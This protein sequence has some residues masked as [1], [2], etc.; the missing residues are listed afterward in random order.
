MWI[1]I[2]WKDARNVWIV[3]DNISNIS[4]HKVW[5]AVK[6]KL[7]THHKTHFSQK[8]ATLLRMDTAICRVGDMHSE[9]TQLFLY[10]SWGEHSVK[11]VC[12]ALEMEA[13]KEE[14]SDVVHF[15]VAEVVGTC[16]IHHLM[17]AVSGKHCMSL[18]KRARVAEEI[19]QRMHI[20]ASWFASRAGLLSLY[21]WYDCVNWWSD[22]GKTTNQ[23]KFMFRSDEEVRKWV[24]LWIHQWLTS[25]Y[26][27]GIDHLVSQSNK[28][29]NT[30]GNYF[31]IKQIPSSLRSR[32]SVFIWLPLI[33]AY[34]YYNYNCTLRT[35]ISCRNII[36][37]L[38]E[39]P[40]VTAGPWITVWRPQRTG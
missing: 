26:K 3:V 40:A 6:W 38:P 7:N 17:S 20:T 4:C 18:N 14:Q 1:N 33:H 34:Y 36:S 19:P 21:A 22:P 16:R 29:I 13:S 39:V 2:S 24:R 31:W 30:S 8:L 12:P 37:V 10:C 11:C 25:F 35:R 9:N 15:L 5:G 28:C 27:T 32:C 23:I